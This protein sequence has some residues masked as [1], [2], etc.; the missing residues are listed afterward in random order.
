MGETKKYTH[1]YKRQI[2]LIFP[3]FS[4]HKIIYIYIHTY[5][6][7]NHESNVTSRLSL[8]VPKCMS[9]HKAMVVVIGRVQ[10]FMITFTLSIL[11]LL[12][13]L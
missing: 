11:C 5:Y 10:F 6:I 4:F 13:H 12:D 2:S 1:I 9:C 8:L 3:N 7:C